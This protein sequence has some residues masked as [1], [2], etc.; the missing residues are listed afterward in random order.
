MHINPPPMVVNLL[1]LVRLSFFFVTEQY[2]LMHF[3][4]IIETKA[5]KAPSSSE[6]ALIISILKEGNTMEDVT[7]CFHN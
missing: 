3:L 2:M 6:Y 5:K 7:D 1:A 4:L